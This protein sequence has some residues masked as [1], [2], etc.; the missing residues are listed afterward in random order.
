MGLGLGPAAAAADGERGFV[1]L[2][3]PHRRSDAGLVLP[4]IGLPAQRLSRNQA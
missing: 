3:R 2:Y 1:S 4:P